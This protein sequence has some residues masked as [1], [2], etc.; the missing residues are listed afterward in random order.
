MSLE[1]FIAG[2]ARN[3]WI[4]DSGLSYYVRKSLF[5]PGVIELANCQALLDSDGLSMWKFLRKYDMKIPFY[6]EQVLNPQLADLMRKLQWTERQV[7]EIPQFASPLMVRLHGE[8][9]RFKQ[10]FGVKS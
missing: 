2:K 5:F 8:S 9:E 10:L 6:M 7:G 1:K 4:A 3:A